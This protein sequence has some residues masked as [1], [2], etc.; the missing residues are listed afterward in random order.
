M[1]YN[2]SNIE[3]EILQMIADGMTTAQIASKRSVHKKTIEMYRSSIKKKLKTTNTYNSVAEA[4]RKD[5]ID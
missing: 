5:I 2:L 3:I 4:I 1:T